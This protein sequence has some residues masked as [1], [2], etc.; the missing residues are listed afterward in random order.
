MRKIYVY[1]SG[2]PDRAAER[3]L[4][5][6]ER[7]KEIRECKNERVRREKHRVWELLEYAVKDALSLDFNNLQFTKTESGKWACDSFEFSLS[8]SDGAVAVAISDAAVGVDIEEVRVIDSRLAAKVLTD[9]EL[10][11]Y[12]GLCDAEREGF[13][14]DSWCKKEAI[15]KHLGDSVLLP[16]RIESSNYHTVTLRVDI[17]GREHV[18][19]VASD[20]EPRVDTRCYR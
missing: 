12:Y 9:S 8:H 16:K 5:P 11:F 17:E 13:L 1:Y 2:I 10:E 19:A 6:D 7:M 15:F 18:I 20:S 3:E 4:Y 14:L